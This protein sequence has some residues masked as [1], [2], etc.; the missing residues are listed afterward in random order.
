MYTYLLYKKGPFFNAT[1]A[2]RQIGIHIFF[3]YALPLPL[4][5]TIYH[6]SSSSPLVIIIIKIRTLFPF[7]IL[8][9]TSVFI[10]YLSYFPIHPFQFHR[11]SNSIFL[12]LSLFPTGKKQQRKKL[13]GEEKTEIHL[14]LNFLLKKKKN[15]KKNLKNPTS[16][17]C[18]SSRLLLKTLPFS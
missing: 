16:T 17:C 6:Y 8:F 9:S 18:S 3:P 2:F 13:R 11:K 7:F 12:S 15:E 10:P 1:G 4:E 5:T 14:L